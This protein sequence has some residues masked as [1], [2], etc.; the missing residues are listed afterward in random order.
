MKKNSIPLKDAKIGTLLSIDK[1]TG[2]IEMVQR[3][4]TLG[5][6]KNRI[7]KVLDKRGDLILIECLQCKYA[8]R[9]NSAKTIMVSEFNKG[10]AKEI[11]REASF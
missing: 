11:E 7:I 3:L 8:I 5:F 2:K 10:T 6:I 1:V 4:N 9:M